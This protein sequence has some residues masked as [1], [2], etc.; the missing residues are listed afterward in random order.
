MILVFVDLTTDIIDET[1]NFFKANVFFKN[2][3]IKV[4]EFWLSYLTE[5]FKKGVAHLENSFALEKHKFG[6][7]NVDR[8][9]HISLFSKLDV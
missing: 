5:A 3:E 8:F 7:K 6:D 2:Y 4:R 1:L 9:H